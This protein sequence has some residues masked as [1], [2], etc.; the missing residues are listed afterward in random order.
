[1]NKKLFLICFFLSISCV[2]SYCV[3]NSI[4][5]VQKRKSSRISLEYLTQTKGARSN[6]IPYIVEVDDQSIGVTYLQAPANIIVEIFNE[7]GECVYRTVADSATNRQLLIG[8]GDWSSGC[9]TIYFK[10]SKNGNIVY[11]EFDL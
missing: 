4:C 1:M 8:T 5:F 3:S 11:G 6:F 10:D 9:Y 2:E 7:L